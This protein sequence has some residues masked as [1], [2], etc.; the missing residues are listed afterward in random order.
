VPV[1]RPPG[2]GSPSRYRLVYLDLASGDLRSRSISF[3]STGGDLHV[4]TTDFDQSGHHLLYT[5]TS[6]DPRAG[7]GTWRSSGS[8]R[9]VRVHDDHQTTTGPHLTTLSPSW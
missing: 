5:V 6:G 8:A 4:S 9:P 2:V 1:Q 7:T 3:D